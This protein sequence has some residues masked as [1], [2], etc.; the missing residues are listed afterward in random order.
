MTLIKMA[1][2]A[3]CLAASSTAAAAATDPIQDMNKACAPQRAAVARFA[4]AHGGDDS[5]LDRYLAN[6]AKTKAADLAKMKA[7]PPKPQAERPQQ[8]IDFVMCAV[9]RRLAQ[10]QK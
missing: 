2:V 1:L 10:L 8:E 5:F 6:I 9:S 4:R 7:N 3:A